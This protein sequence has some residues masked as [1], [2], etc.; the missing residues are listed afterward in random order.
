MGYIRIIGMVGLLAGM[1][2]AACAAPASEPATG[3][4]P[5]GEQPTR[6]MHIYRSPTCGCCSNWVGYVQEHGYTVTV[7]D[8]QDMAAIKAEHNVPE[9]TWSCHTA[10][11]D[12][13]VV[14]GH[15]PVE[16]IERLLRERPDVAGIA[17]PGMP[18][19]SPGREVDGVAPQP[20]DVVTFDAAGATE[21]FSSHHQ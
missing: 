12:G 4:A 3:A 21:V 1:L 16:D 17:A 2:L 10:L 6:T 14:E 5:T 13:Y 18:T 11:I 19:G 15:V 20:F 7:E 9:S 8:V